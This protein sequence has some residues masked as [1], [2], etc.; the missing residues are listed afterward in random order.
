M[1]AKILLLSLLTILLFTACNKGGNT[2][3]LVPAD[4][5]MVTHIDLNSLSSKLSWDEIKATAWFAEAQKEIKDSLLKNLLNNPTESGVNTKGSIVFFFKMNTDGGGYAVVE[6]DVQDAKK[7]ADVITKAGK[8]KITVQKD[9]EYNF[10][11][12]DGKAVVYFNDKKLI[13]VSG[14]ANFSGLANQGIQKEYAIDSLKNYAKKILTLKGKDLLDNDERFTKLVT[15]KS[16]MHYWVNAGNMYNG[17]LSGMAAMMKLDVFLKGAVTSASINF[18]KGKITLNST[19]HYGKE[20]TDFYKK[21]EGKSISNEA[22]QKLPNGDALFAMAAGFNPEGIKEF[23]KLI[24]VDGL[25]NMGL[26]QIGITVDDFVNANKGQLVMALTD[27]GFSNEKKSVDLGNG[28][29]YEYTNNRPNPQFVLGMQVGDKAAFQKLVDAIKKYFTIV[30]DTSK[31]NS[32]PQ[33]Q[34]SDNW[35]AISNDKPTS[36]TFVNGNSTNTQTYSNY[37]KG[38][39]MGLY[40][41]IQKIIESTTTNSKDTATL[42]AASISKNFWRVAGVSA[43]LKK[44]EWISKG[45]ITLADANTNALKQLNKYIDEMAQ[46]GIQENKRRKANTDVEFDMPRAVDS[47]ITTSQN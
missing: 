28:E 47:A 35:F 45:E 37:L 20:M 9:G 29:K 10:V 46:I 38:N 31:N 2:G 22:L 14:S 26:R 40:F 41:N 43:N 4:A 18:D 24:G 27:L 44:G 30:D 34:L 23:A 16:D 8:G 7:L 13:V 19:Q 6:T 1:K 5:G 15:D 11:D 33:L 42:Q 21:H 36:E 32:M 3:L 12:A 25:M 39:N 17:V